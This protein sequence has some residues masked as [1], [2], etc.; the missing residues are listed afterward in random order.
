MRLL[1]GPVRH[2]PSGSGGYLVWWVL[3][4]GCEAPS[5]ATARQV[6]GELGHHCPDCGKVERTALLSDL[7]L[8]DGERIG[9]RHR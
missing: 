5:I 9:R 8:A 7:Q 1:S 6:A 4:G 2:S 3:C